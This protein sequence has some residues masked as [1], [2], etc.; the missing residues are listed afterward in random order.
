[1]KQK[2]HDSARYSEKENYQGGEEQDLL[3]SKCDLPTSMVRNPVKM[4]F[5]KNIFSLLLQSHISYTSHP[6]TISVVEKFIIDEIVRCNGIHLNNP[7]D[8]HLL[9]SSMRFDEALIYCK[10]LPGGSFN[11][12]SRFYVTFE[13][14][15]SYIRYDGNIVP[16]TVKV[17]TGFDILSIKQKFTLS[18]IYLSKFASDYSGPEEDKMSQDDLDAYN[19]L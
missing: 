15:D 2:F 3:L 1:M 17:I 19:D 6:E 5:N 13:T 9:L 12:Y 8:L 16:E 4:I 10:A 18:F 14:Q 7:I 11:N